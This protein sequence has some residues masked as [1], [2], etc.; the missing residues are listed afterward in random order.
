MTRGQAV[1]AAGAATVVVLITI[2]S[3]AV[4][5]LISNG[6]ITFNMGGSAAN[7]A[8]A[9]DPNYASQLEKRQQALDQAASVMQQ[10]Q[11]GF[12]GQ[13][14][15]ANQNIETL[16]QT[17]AG[18]QAQN[19]ADTQTLSTLQGQVTAAN[20]TVAG[21]SAEAKTWQDKEAGYAAQIEAENQQILA[22][23]AQIAQMTGQQP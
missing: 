16:K 8:L 6:T 15:E 21:L 22:L 14:E 17:I 20:N 11:E 13:I 18:Q 9:G 7:A 2:L 3:I 5:N 4:I 23:K 12:A 10:R 1:L 19:A